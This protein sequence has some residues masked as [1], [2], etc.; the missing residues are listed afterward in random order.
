[1]RQINQHQQMI[2]VPLLALLMLATRGHHDFS[3][4][5]FYFFSGRFVDTSLAESTERFMTY[6]PGNLIS[7]AL[8]LGLAALVHTLFKPARHKIVQKGDVAG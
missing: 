1:M 8:Y 5:G 6:L 3:P 2:I 7:Q 4:G